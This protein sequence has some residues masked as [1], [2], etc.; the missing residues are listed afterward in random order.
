MSAE[1][2]G[3]VIAVCVGSGGIPKHPVAEAAVT[4]LGLEGDGHRFHLHG[5]PNRAVCLFSVA[6][7]AALA[8]DGVA[9]TAPGAFGENLLLDGVDFE[10]L[11]PGDR[12]TVGCGDEP[13]D[14]AA[15]VLE[16]H[17]VREPCGTLKKVDRRFPNLMVGRSGWLCRVVT[18]GR[19]RPGDTVRVEPGP[20]RDGA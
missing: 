1:S 11:R 16:I 14:S 18:G 8:R 19:V 7:Y 9:A 3:R 6:D 10:R 4:A 15:V 2:S 20:R 12:L 17:D 5:G 13:G